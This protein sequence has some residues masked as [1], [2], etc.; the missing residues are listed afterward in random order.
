MK[1]TIFLIIAFLCIINVFA[2][3]PQAFNYQ[4]IVRNAS[5]IVLQNQNVSLRI[6]LLQGST[7]GTP[8]FVESHVATSNTFGLVNIKI[9]NGA[10][11]SGIFTSIDW[12]AGP[13]FINIEIDATGGSTF[14]EMGVSQLMS[15]PYALFAAS[16]N[17]GLQGLQGLPGVNGQNGISVIWLGTFSSHP[18]NPI[19]NNAYYNSADKKSYIYDGAGWQIIAQDGNQGLQGSSGSNGQNGISMVW[20]GTFTSHPLNPA[21]NNAYYNSTDKKSYIF[22]G[23]GWQIIAQDGMQGLQGIPGPAGTYFAGIGINISNDTIS[24]INASYSAGTGL[25]LIGTTFNAI[26]GSNA[27]SISEGNHTHVS[28]AVGGTNGN[29]QFNNS[30]EFGGNNFLFWDNNN[31]RLGIGTSS[32]TSTLHINGTLRIT[33]D[34]EGAGKVLTSDIDGYTSWQLPSSST[35]NGTQNRIAKFTSPNSLGNSLFYENGNYIGLGTTTPFGKLVVQGDSLSADSVPLFEVKD[36]NGNTVFVVWPTGAHFYIESASVAKTA[37][38]GSFAVSGKSNSKNIVNEFFS[39]NSDSIKASKSLYIPRMTTIERDTLGFIPS[40]A[41]IIFNT[42]DKCMQ[43]YENGVWSNIWCFNCAPAFIIQPVD[44]TICSEANTNFFVSLTGTNLTYQWQKSI[45]GGVTWSDISNG[46]A[47]PSYF[48]ATSWSL[49]LS[50]IPVG[51]NGYKFRCNVFAACPPGVISNV[52]TLNVGSTPPVISTQPANQVLSVGCTASFNIIS[53]GFGVTY[54]WQASIDGG[55]TWSIIS[56]G[57]T[58]PVYAGATTA[59]ISLSNVSLANN[60]YKYLCVVGNSCGSNVTSTSVSLTVS[61]AP[62][63]TTQPSDLQLPNSHTATFNIVVSGT[64]MLYQWQ[65]STDGGTTWNDIINGGASPVY[66]GSA[67]SSLLMTNV[68]PSY[69]GFKYRC[70]IN[71][72]CRPSTTSNAAT[73]TISIPTLTTTVAG[74]ITS[75]TA[76]SGGNVS[77]DGGA[78]VT[79]RGVCWSTST[80]PVATDSHTTDGTGTGSFASSL[81]GLIPGF[82]YYVR[83]YATNSLGTAYGNQISFT[84]NTVDIGQSYQGGIVAYILQPGDPGNIAGQTHGLIAAPSDQSTGIQ[85]YNGSYIVTGATATILGTGNTNTNTIVTMQGAGSYAA[86]LC[87]DLVLG[88]YSDWYLPS[89]DELNKL[90]INRVLIGGFVS[91]YLSSSEVDANTVWRQVFTTGVQGPVNKVSAYYVRAV[92]SF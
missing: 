9:G 28:Y 92:R 91:T 51:F 46:G 52:V 47:N 87:A 48:G 18:V 16:G 55:S 25:N 43:I 81:T 76:T 13:Y 70:I 34:T 40:E 38:R 77:L 59:S 66:S 2:Q 89:K 26:F 27:G 20:L 8:V 84:T 71:H 15:V 22:D 62:T 54:E 23:L 56:N 36:K 61:P 65:E 60:N 88:G 68:P 72:F 85:W 41:L 80:N 69:S 83:A 44:Q 78:T 35:S 6:S 63:I 42:T 19:T 64:G 14:I 82:T 30:G 45:D 75:V 7:T 90:F 12:S 24:S 50:N 29:L 49:S 86:Q 57:G 39:V 32:P 3:S 58:S 1:Q 33:D 31:L 5:G 21:T 10:V 53:P 74:S 67:A 11:L 17:Q 37:N 73:L 79:A 4:A